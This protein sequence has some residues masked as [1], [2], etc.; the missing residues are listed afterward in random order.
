MNHQVFLSYSHENLNDVWRLFRGLRTRHVPVWFDKVQLKPGPW[1]PQIEKA[2]AQSRYFV[3]CLSIAALRKLG[4]TSP[5]FQDEELSHAYM[6]ARMQPTTS[7]TIVPVLLELCERGDFR[8]SGFQQYELFAGWDETLDRLALHLASPNVVPDE[9]HQ[10]GFFAGARV[11]DDVM[12]AGRVAYYAGDFDTALAKLELAIQQGYE[13]AWHFMGATL[14]QLKQYNEA[15]SA[16]G[17]AVAYCPDDAYAWANLARVYAETGRHD[18]AVSAADTACQAARRATHQTY[19]AKDIQGFLLQKAESLG[20]QRD[21][22]GA[23]EA[24]RQAESEVSDWVV[25]NARAGM[26]YEFA[27][28]HGCLE[29]CRR[30]WCVDDTQPSPWALAALAHKAIGEY[31]SA[32]ACYERILTLVPPQSTQHHFISKELSKIHDL[33]DDPSKLERRQHPKYY[34]ALVTAAPTASSPDADHVGGAAAVIFIL[35]DSDASARDML[36]AHFAARHWTVQSIEE[37]SEIPTLPTDPD[38]EEVRRQVAR[39]GIA[40]QLIPWKHP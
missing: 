18:R 26:C 40:V 4:E 10:A 32:A 15:N 23:L 21:I 22:C 12:E 31:M 5:G 13:G 20:K 38:S 6:I 29:A 11:L 17:T 27:D 25:H 2:I 14:G 7:F 8:L 19:S 9:P 34:S 1:K 3:I 39:D 36:A 24:L 28:F 16:L 37:F 30:A 33:P 35:S